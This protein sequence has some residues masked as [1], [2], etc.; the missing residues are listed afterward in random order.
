MVKH[1]I[2]LKE[3]S[4]RKFD[5]VWVVFDKDSFPDVNFNNAIAKAEAD[6]INAAWTNE[7]FELWFLLHFQFVNT[8]MNRDKYKAYLEREVKK[9][10]GNKS[11]KYKKNDPETY[12]L[13]KKHGNWKQAI[14][15]AEQLKKRFKNTRYATHNP[16]TLVHELIKELYNPHGVLEKINS[17]E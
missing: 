12:S 9:K 14:D 2:K 13:L 3:K 7:A 16:C 11:Y 10:T 6:N 1:T 4:L 5:R 17:D 15:W 8:A